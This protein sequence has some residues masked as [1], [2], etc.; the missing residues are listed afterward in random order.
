TRKTQLQLLA[1]ATAINLKRL[2]RAHAGNGEQQTGTGG[3]HLASVIGL[4]EL[5]TPC[6]TE[7][8]LLSQTER[9]TGS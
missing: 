8:E 7:L 2:L 4:L 5:L 9:S 3:T 6:L 1:A